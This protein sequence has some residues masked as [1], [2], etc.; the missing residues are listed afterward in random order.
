MSRQGQDEQQRNTGSSHKF[1]R[2][3]NLSHIFTS[4]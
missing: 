2:R 4:A 1:L 3:M